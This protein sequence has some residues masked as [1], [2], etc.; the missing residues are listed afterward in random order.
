MHETSPDHREGEVIGEAA[1][2]LHDGRPPA[3]ARHGEGGQGVSKRDYYEVLG[4]DGH[5]TEVEMKSAYRKLALKH[6]PDRNPGDKAPRK[7]SRSAPRR[8]RFSPTPTSA[9]R[10]TGSATGVSQAGSAVRSDDL[11]RLRRHPR[12]PRR[13]LR[14]RRSVRRRPAARRP[15]ARRR[16]ALR[17]RDHVRG[18]GEG[19]GNEHPDSAAGTLRDLQRIGRGARIV[20]NGVPPVP[21]PGTGAVP[22]GLLHGRAHVPAVPRHRPDDR[23]AVSHLPRRG[24][25]R[26]ERKITVKIPAGIAT[27][28]QL[29]L[30]GEGEGGSAGGP[31]GNL[32]T[33]SSTC[34][35]TSSSGATA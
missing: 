26:E 30:Q 16:S 23:Q 33:S 6:H 19:R 22:A 5:A 32:C 34:R 3:P 14:V 4:V 1:E 11:R 10:T 12:R 25:R 7:S 8:T 18:I 29:R 9:R 13:H 21:G 27:G 20:A 35:S 31:A 2:G 28:Q 17:P 15:A 24:P